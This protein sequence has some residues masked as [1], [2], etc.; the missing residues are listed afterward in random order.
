M[1]KKVL[2]AGFDPKKANNSPKIKS[3]LALRSLTIIII[4]LSWNT[5]ECK[6]NYPKSI[7]WVPIVKLGAMGKH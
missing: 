4:N 7:E 3:M 6:R 2:P 5:S 1:C